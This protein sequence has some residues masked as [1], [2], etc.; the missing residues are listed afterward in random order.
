M[1]TDQNESWQMQGSDPLGPG[2]EVGANDD[3]MAPLDPDQAPDESDEE[4][5]I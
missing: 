4:G 2:D 5:G 1:K 3:E